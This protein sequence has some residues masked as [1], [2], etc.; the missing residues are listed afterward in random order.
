MLKTV[1]KYNTNLAAI[2]LSAMIM[3]AL[4]VWYH[5]GAPQRP[6]T[7]VMSKCLLNKHKI[8]TIAELIKSANIILVR[9]QSQDHIPSP[10]CICRD[11]VQD[12]RDSCKNPQACTEEALLR[13]NEIAPKYNPLV[14]SAHNNLSL[15]HRR[16]AKNKVLISDLCALSGSMDTQITDCF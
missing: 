12:R 10:A 14:I 11:C 3:L 16:I 1:K 5:P 4:A 8:S 15:T 9:N 2:R 7:N 6:L 13:L